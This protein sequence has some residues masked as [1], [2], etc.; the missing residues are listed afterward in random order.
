MSTLEEAGYVYNPFTTLDILG[1]PP[2]FNLA[3]VNNKT[4]LPVG[5]DNS[6]HPELAKPAYGNPEFHQGSSRIPFHK[7]TLREAQMQNNM[8]STVLF[9]AVLAVAILWRRS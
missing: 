6:A 7:P 5:A 4:V 2:P 1:R 8:Y 9:V 3:A